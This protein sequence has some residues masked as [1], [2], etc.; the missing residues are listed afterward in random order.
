MNLRRAEQVDSGSQLQ[1]RFFEELQISFQD[2]PPN[3]PVS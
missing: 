2:W 1:L 3:K